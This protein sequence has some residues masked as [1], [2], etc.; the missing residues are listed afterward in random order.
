ML[1]VTLC[2]VSCDGLASHPGRSSD[3][4]GCFML[5]L[6]PRAVIPLASAMDRELWWG[7]G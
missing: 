4:L 3:A 2:W 7:P 5:I 6:V 1:L